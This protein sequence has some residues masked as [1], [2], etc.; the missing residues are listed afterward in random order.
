METTSTLFSLLLYKHNLKESSQARIDENNTKVNTLVNMT[1]IISGI[2]M[3][4]VGIIKYRLGIGHKNVLPGLCISILGVILNSLFAIK[5]MSSLKHHYEPIIHSQ[6]RLYASKTIVDTCV[7]STM[8]VMLIF[9]TWKYLN[10]LDAL[11]SIL[12]AIILCSQG[13]INLKN[14][15]FEGRIE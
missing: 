5:Y 12:V 6:F 13:F 8:S 15:S 7:A 11:T 14:K 3:I 2:L 1:L 10:L 9:P 4:F